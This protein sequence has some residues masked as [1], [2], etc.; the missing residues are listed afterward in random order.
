MDLAVRPLLSGWSQGIPFLIKYLDNPKFPL[1]NDT[2]R[3]VYPFLS[4]SFK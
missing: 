1:I 3:G 2:W 4:T